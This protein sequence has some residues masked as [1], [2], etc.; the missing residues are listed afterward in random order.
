MTAAAA[1]LRRHH[2]RVTPQRLLLVDLAQRIQGHF[3]A[4]HLHQQMIT[5]YPSISLV[6][7]YRGLET[8]REEGL[9]TRTIL[10]DV[11]ASYE[12]VSDSRHHHLVCT[13][14]GGHQDLNDHELDDLRQHL[15]ANYHF[16]AALDHLA[17]FG[18][19]DACAHVLP[20]NG[21]ESPGGP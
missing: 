8:L 18:R 13:I 4:E 19:C 20:A 5:V 15:H 21:S 11:A 3:S 6:S 1:L 12:W 10:G 7:V 16:H 17:I 2:L 14:C 9:V